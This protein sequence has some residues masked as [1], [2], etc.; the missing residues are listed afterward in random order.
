MIFDDDGHDRYSACSVQVDVN[1]AHTHPKIIR[2]L[3]GG[4]FQ[5]IKQNVLINV[6]EDALNFGILSAAQ[7]KRTRMLTW[8]DFRLTSLNS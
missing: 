2:S 3:W 1:A 4:V 6:V 7:G 8:M 5:A